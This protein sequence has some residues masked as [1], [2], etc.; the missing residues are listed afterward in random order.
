MFKL[1]LLWVL[2]AII[3]W[4]ELLNWGLR[5]LNKSEHRFSKQ[6]KN[7]DYRVLLNKKVLAQ[8]IELR[9][10]LR[11]RFNHSETNNII[12]YRSRGIKQFGW[13]LEGRACQSWVLKRC[14][15]AL[16]IQGLWGVSR[17]DELCWTRVEIFLVNLVDV[18][19]EVVTWIELVGPG[20]SHRLESLFNLVRVNS[21]TMFWLI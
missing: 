16:T 20:F 18:E 17:G 8:S 2:G 11:T 10:V 19:A 21:F 3:K 13:S 1:N 5:F 14:A 12:V 15:C 9:Y 7:L 6:I 4:H